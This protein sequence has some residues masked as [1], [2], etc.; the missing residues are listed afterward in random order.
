MKVKNNNSSKSK[1]I[2]KLFSLSKYPSN[3][4]AKKNQKKELPSIIISK[5]MP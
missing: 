2:P 4:I 5:S 3:F 1:N